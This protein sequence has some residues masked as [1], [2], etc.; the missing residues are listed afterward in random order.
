[1]HRLNKTKRGD[2][3]LIGPYD[4][5]LLCKI[6]TLPT[7]I[8]TWEPDVKAWRISPSGAAEV[9][10]I[11]EDHYLVG[12]DIGAQMMARIRELEETVSAQGEMLSRL[13]RELGVVP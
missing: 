7:P 8:R 6:R 11:V 9:R 10:R 13:Y 12:N 1:M 3:L 4:E 5:E 2:Y